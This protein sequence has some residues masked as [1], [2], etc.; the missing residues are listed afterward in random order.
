MNLVEVLVCV[1]TNLMGLS[2]TVEV[3]VVGVVVVVV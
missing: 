3:V 2:L 1:T